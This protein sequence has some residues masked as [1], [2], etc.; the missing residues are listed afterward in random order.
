MARDYSDGSFNTRFHM[1][2]MGKHGRQ[3]RGSRGGV[4][5]SPSD[6]GIPRVPHQLGGGPCGQQKR[7]SGSIWKQS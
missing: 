7:R 5:A 4:V 1:M 2:V 3:R 6:L